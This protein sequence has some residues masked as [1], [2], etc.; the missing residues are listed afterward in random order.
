MRE[1]VIKDALWSFVGLNRQSAAMTRG[2]DGV[3]SSIPYDM[4]P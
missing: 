1:I 3:G 2:I 4:V